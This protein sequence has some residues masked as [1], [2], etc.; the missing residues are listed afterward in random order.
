MS[1]APILIRDDPRVDFEWYSVSPDPLLPPDHFSVRWTRELYFPAGRFRFAITH[2]DG[3]RF[4]IDDNLVLKNWCD[5]CRET[6]SV[7]HAMTAGT[8]KLVFEMFENTGWSAAKLS[9]QD[10]EGTC[11][12]FILEGGTPVFLP[13]GTNEP[14]LIDAYIFD[15]FE[16]GNYARIWDPAFFDD[17]GPSW[18][19][20]NVKY[21]YAYSQVNPEASCGPPPRPQHLSPE[22]GSTFEEGESIVLAWHDVPGASSYRAFYFGG[23][24]GEQSSGWQSNTSWDIASPPGGVTY[25][26]SV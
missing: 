9:W 15:I 19:Y 17:L 13:H 4:Y 1:G 20:P 24:E 21:V 18:G 11:G 26:W 16:E 22:N 14:W 25:Y 8:H 5:N 3:A 6:D 12:V 23:P 7:E 10:L 2:D